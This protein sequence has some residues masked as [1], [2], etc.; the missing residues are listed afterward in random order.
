[1]VFMSNYGFSEVDGLVTAHG[2]WVS[3]TSDLA[4]P[5]Q[6]VEIECFRQLGH[7]FSYTA[8]LSEGNYLSVS[9][10]LYEI[11][12]WGDD[13]VITKPNE[14]KCVEYQLTLN[15]RS[16]TVTNIRHTIDN[17]SEFCVGTQDEP[18]TLTLGDGDQRVQK[19]KTKN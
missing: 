12:T 1:M 2:S 14:F 13:A 5:L 7:C 9:S 16:K 11:E 18:I 10:E 15:R 6:T 3:P 19:Y 4:N 8:E 17:K